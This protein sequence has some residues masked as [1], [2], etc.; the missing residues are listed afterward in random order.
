MRLEPRP[1]TSHIVRSQ[2][3]QY[4]AAQGEPGEPQAWRDSVRVSLSELGRARSAQAQRNSDIEES[5][6]PDSIKQLLKLIRELKAQIA[7]KQAELAALM[8]DSGLDA[9]VRLRQAQTFQSELTSLNAALVS[10]NA[11]LLEA[12][13]ELGLDD[14]QLQA[15][16]LLAMK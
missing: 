16:T 9:E 4:A 11:N 8:A 3:R 10:A 6:L 14:A 5:N 1:L 15:A 7:A 2:Q 12:M 13:S